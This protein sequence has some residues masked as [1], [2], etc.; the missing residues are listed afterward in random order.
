MTEVELKERMLGQI[1]WDGSTATSERVLLRASVVN[2]CRVERNQFVRIADPH[3]S[4]TGFLATVASG[5]F[6]H[7]SGSPTIGGL[8]AGHSLEAFLLADLEIQG[9]LVDGR[10]RD[11]NSRPAP[12]SSV[13]ALSPAEIA[14]CTASTA[15]CSWAISPARTTCSSACRAR[16][17][18][19]CRA[20]SA[21]SARSARA[22]RTRP[23]CSSRR[24]RATAGRSSSST[25]KANTPR[26]TSRRETRPWSSEL[27]PLRP[28]SRRA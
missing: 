10:S 16:T 4:R 14:T 15:T 8:T 25:S 27:A 12:G 24:R 7:R 26:W 23:R 2:R 21:S 22:N 20:T 1:T 9:E 13:Y 6:F 5:P 3:G 19:C 28:R 11:T 17:R 18:A